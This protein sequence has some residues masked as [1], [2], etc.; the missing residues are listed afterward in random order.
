MRWKGDG[1][2]NSKGHDPT[3]NREK[4]ATVSG[5]AK[6]EFFITYPNIKVSVLMLCKRETMVVMR[7]CLI[8]CPYREKNLQEG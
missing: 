3:R 6:A 1:I 4:E 2:N 7:Y 5:K 8:I